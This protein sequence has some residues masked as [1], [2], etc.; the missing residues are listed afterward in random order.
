MQ[1]LHAGRRRRLHPAAVSLVVAARVSVI[2]G[3]VG[4]NLIASGESLIAT[5]PGDWHTPEAGWHDCTSAAAAVGAAL[6]PLET[7]TR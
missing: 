3:T 2:E 1:P 6:S 7:N 5:L 4:P